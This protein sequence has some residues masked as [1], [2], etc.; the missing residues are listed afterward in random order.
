M[1]YQTSISGQ[2]CCSALPDSSELVIPDHVIEGYSFN[3][4]QVPNQCAPSVVNTLG[5]LTFPN[6]SPDEVYYIHCV[7]TD[8]VS[9]WPS[10]MSYTTAKSVPFVTYHS[11]LSNDMEI[12]P[13]AGTSLSMALLLWLGLLY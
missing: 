1:Q 5:T 6:L 12:L 11:P 7:A 2:V 4:T 13:A 10:V 9:L 3:W 8:N